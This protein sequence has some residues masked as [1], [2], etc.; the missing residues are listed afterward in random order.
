[1]RVICRR[2]IIY[3]EARV[4]LQLMV[5]DRRSAYVTE[6]TQQA[7]QA[8]QQGKTEPITFVGEDRT[9]ANNPADKLAFSTVLPTQCPDIPDTEQRCAM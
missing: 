5:N 1:V 6:P 3:H 4:L 8:L 2:S 9:Q 7:Q